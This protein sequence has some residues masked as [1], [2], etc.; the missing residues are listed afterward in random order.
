MA[1]CSSSGASQK[2]PFVPK[3]ALLTSSPRRGSAAKTRGDAI[4][5]V[6]RA[7]S[8]ARISAAIAVRGGS[9]ARE[10]FQTVVRRAIRRRS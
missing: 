10:V 4:D 8:A 3:P 6:E 9:S 7:R 2:R 1:T 5:V